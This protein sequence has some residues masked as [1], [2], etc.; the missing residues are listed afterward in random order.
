MCFSFSSP[1]SHSCLRESLHEQTSVGAKALTRTLLSCAVAQRVLKHWDKT[2]PHQSH[3][4]C[5]QLVR[6]V[7]G[8]AP[9]SATSPPS[10]DSVVSPS[11]FQSVV[12]L[13]ALPWQISHSCRGRHVW[14]LMTKRDKM[15][16]RQKG[17]ARGEMSWD[18]RS[19]GKV[20]IGEA[21]GGRGGIKKKRANEDG[22]KKRDGPR[23]NEVR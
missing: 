19:E 5:S 2:M 20:R 23:K 4:A 1:L 15:W 3:G 7:S 14:L 21:S 11:L 18:E 16:I 8:Y 17:S 13:I 9:A 12:T 22:R 6:S 10:I